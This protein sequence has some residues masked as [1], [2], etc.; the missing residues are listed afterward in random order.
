MKGAHTIDEA[1]LGIMLNDL[2]LMPR[3]ASSKIGRAH[4]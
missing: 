2:R 4:V 3:R 1:R